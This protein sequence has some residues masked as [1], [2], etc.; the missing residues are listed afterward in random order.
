MNRITTRLI[1]TGVA[2]TFLAGCGFA[3]TWVRTFRT[4]AIYNVVDSPI[5]PVS[6]KVPSLDQVTKAI[7]V[8]GTDPEV[9]WVMA[10]AKPGHIVG[11]HNVF[12]HQAVVDIAY[13]TKTYSIKFKNASREFRYDAAKQTIHSNYNEEIEILDNAIRA[14]L[15]AIDS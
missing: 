3:D 12:V 14:R 5:A 15:A 6:G 8:A 10:V 13:D 9:K 2:L 11:I 1:M 7:V 4:S